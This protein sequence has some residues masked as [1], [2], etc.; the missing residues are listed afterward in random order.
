[1]SILLI[2]INNNCISLIL[3]KHYYYKK[4]ELTIINLTVSSIT[5]LVIL[6]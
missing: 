1:M 5:K 2:N 4:I 6:Y 3:S